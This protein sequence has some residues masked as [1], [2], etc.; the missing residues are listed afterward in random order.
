M[1]TSFTAALGGLRSNQRWIDVIG[2]NLANQNTPGF[3]GSRA[4]FGDLLSLTYRPGTGPN[5]SQGG[6]NPLQVGLGAQ[7]A[8]TDRRLDQ[9]ALDVTGRTFD[10][11]LLGDGYFAATDGNQTFYTRVGTFGLDAGGN[12]V[13]LT[14]GFR[15]L[16]ANGQ[17]F[18]IDT[19]AVI[20]PSAT[21]EVEFT[22]NLPAVVTGPLAE[23]LTSSSSF[24]EG[25]P[26]TTTGDTAGPFNIPAGETWT[27]ELVIDGGAPQEVAILG[28]GAITT[29]EVADAINDQT[30]DV[31]ATVAPGGELTLTSERAGENATIK[32][33]AG[34]AGKDLKN[35]VGL[36][37]FVQGSESDATAAT[38]LN[39]LA[40]TLT[41]YQTG[42][43]IDVA[44]TDADGSTVVTS[45]TYG[46]D[47][48]TLGDFVGFLDTAF[49][50]STV[51]FDPG[52][53][54]IS[55]TSD[56]VGEA[57]LSLAVT[58]QVNQE[59]RSDWATHFFA[60]TTN[61]TGP[62][63]VTSSIETFD[64][65]G[66]S[67]ILTFDFVRQE[68]GS[69]NMDATLPPEDGE[70]L[71]GTVA[72]ITFNE[73]GSI[74]SPTSADLTV[75]FDGQAAQTITVDFG[76]SGQFEGITQF[77]N[78]ASLI[79]EEQ[80][81]YGAGELASMQVDEAGV[82]EGFFTNGETQTLAAFGIASFA[83][84]GGLEAVGDNYF[85]ESANTGQRVFG[86][87]GAN[88]NGDVVGGAIEASNVDTAVEFVHLIQAQRGFQ[89]NARVI[90]VQDELLAEVVNI[91]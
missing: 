71:N 7:L 35:M 32:I 13:D 44:G 51:A 41:D 25:A 4:L 16:D 24:A 45:F 31:V 67:H 6:T 86:A 69:W 90:T 50:Q 40:S 10:L 82:I 14:S 20:P 81:G 37:D 76:T 36:V 70:V 89:S 34:E 54:Q 43:V 9:G 53:G 47:G 78:P 83:N 52:T 30:E 5:G 80:D 48:T 88:G 42:D 33:N 73:N 3:K 11:A 84:E 49:G 87:G 26:A 29:Q 28:T 38:D 58:D 15:V 77:G 75:Q 61:G 72:G 68:D 22:G 55:V 1:S 12:M 2:N 63:T 19:R 91:I 85:Q 62:D 79:A 60:V 64:A 8:G 23:E 74:L 65:S 21:S 18:T 27:M 57:E 66:T 56:V 59:G 17:P 39:D 46:V